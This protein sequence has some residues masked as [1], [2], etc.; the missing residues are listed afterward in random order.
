MSHRLRWLFSFN[1]P[2]TAPFF[3][4][5]S[6]PASLPGPFLRRHRRQEP[7]TCPGWLGGKARLL[8]AGGSRQLARALPPG[9]GRESQARR[10]S[11]IEVR[12][13]LVGKRG[14]FASLVLRAD[15]DAAAVPVPFCPF[16]RPLLPVHFCHFF[17]RAVERS[18]VRSRRQSTLGTEAG[19]LWGGGLALRFQPLR[20]PAWR[21]WSLSEAAGV[22]SGG[23][24]RDCATG[25]PSPAWLTYNLSL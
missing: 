15:R 13:G 19:A 21:R 17:W 20:E 18:L 1:G 3:P 23:G 4:G 16:A 25:L 14:S 5:N 11:P 24:S 7:G 2:L 8:K 12:R 22:R 10:A 9:S 6:A